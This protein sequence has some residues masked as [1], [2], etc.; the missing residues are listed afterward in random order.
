MSNLT[1]PRQSGL[2]SPLAG[3]VARAA[4]K[5]PAKTGAVQNTAARRVA[6]RGTIILADV[7]HSMSEFAN[8]RPKIQILQNA[9]DGIA[10]NHTPIVAFSRRVRELLPGQRLPEPDGSTALHLALSFCEARNPE[11]IIVISD[12]HPD[13]PGQALWIADRLTGT[14]IDVIY[15]GPET[16][17][18]GIEFMRRL[19]RGGG[20]AEVINLTREPARLSSQVR[21]LIGGPK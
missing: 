10:Q 13:D 9:L 8:G 6:R 14:R 2:T 11:R 21:L 19:A 1:K 15:C 4:E 17:A 5:I 20:A 7:S 16:D 12:G 3:L 18:V